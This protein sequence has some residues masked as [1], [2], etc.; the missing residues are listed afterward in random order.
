MPGATRARSSIDLRSGKDE[1]DEAEHEREMDAA[2]R[3]LAQQPEAA[4]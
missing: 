4:V 2:M 3:R 1:E